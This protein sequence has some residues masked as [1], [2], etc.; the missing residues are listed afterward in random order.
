MK[1]ET[2]SSKKKNTGTA[3]PK[4]FRGISP[5]AFEHEADRAALASLRKMAGFESLLKK[6]VGAFGEKRLRLL[7][8]ANA[9]RINEKQNPE[10]HETFVEACEI[11]DLEIV[12]ELYVTQSPDLNAMA[13]GIDQPFVV[14]NSAMVDSCSHEELRCVLGHEAGHILS[15]HA[16][17]RTMLVVLLR[18]MQAI[19]P[20]AILVMALPILLA[21][22]EWSRKSELSADRAGLLVSQDLEVSLQVCLKLAGGGDI[23]N[24]NL[25]EFEKQAEE[26]HNE[27]TGTD[28]L[29]KF[30]NLMWFSHPFPVLRILE[31]KKWHASEQ[32]RRILAGDYRHR[33]E[34]EES[35]MKKD[36]RE[37]VEIYRESVSDGKES[38]NSFFHAALGTGGDFFQDISDFLREKKETFKTSVP[39]SK[40]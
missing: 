40:V 9:V 13:V 17:Y 29:F 26:Y 34:Y 35:D 36:I 18:T 20:R 39:S 25:E 22:Q 11:L 12:P 32:Y 38:L 4:I 19:M 3:K 8:L 28:T 2:K 1:N 30:L 15:G 21:L 14:V 5:R 33:R 27:G 10:L 23:S 31:M 16:L 6:V 37:G 24:Y 7:F